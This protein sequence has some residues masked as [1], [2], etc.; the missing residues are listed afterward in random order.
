MNYVHV[1]R[2]LNDL[3]NTIKISEDGGENLAAYGPDPDGNAAFN[4]VKQGD[5]HWMDNFV[6]VEDRI[7]GTK[8]WCD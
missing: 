5:W 2:R 8:F 4:R 7:T 3:H 6:G 1:Y